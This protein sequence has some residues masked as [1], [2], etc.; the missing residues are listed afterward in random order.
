MPVDLITLWEFEEGKLNK[1]QTIDML[2]EMLASG[3]I[4]NLPNRYQR[5]ANKYIKLKILSEDGE[6]YA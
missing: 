6:I 4:H 5:L 1:Q 3:E 2:S